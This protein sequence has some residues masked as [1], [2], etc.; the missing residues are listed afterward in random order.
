VNYCSGACELACSRPALGPA[1]SPD[2]ASIAFSLI[3][4]EQSDLYLVGSGGSGLRP[5]ADS[6]A[7]ESWPDWSPDGTR[8]AYST[9]SETGTIMVADADGSGAQ[10]LAI[11][12]E[13]VWGPD[14]S[15]DGSRIA[16]TAN[17]GENADIYTIQLD[18]SGLARI[19][20]DPAWDGNPDW[21]PDGSR[22][23]FTTWRNDNG[24]LYTARADGSDEQN[25]SENSAL[26]TDVATWS[27]DGKQI[28]F[29]ASGHSSSQG[30]LSQPLGIT[31][32]LLQSLILMGFVLRPS[33]AG[34][35]PSAGWRSF[36]I[37]TLMMS[38]MND[39]FHGPGD[40]PGGAGGDLL[41]LLKPSEGR[42]RFY[43]YIFAFLV[44]AVAYALYF[45]AVAIT[46]EL[47]WTIHLW[48]GTIV[49]AG[50]AG[51]LLA[52]LLA[53]FNREAVA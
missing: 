33:C 17:D 5:I 15:P 16:F 44:P 23:V 30:W 21:S 28:L 3:Q 9:H 40:G 4:E 50:V 46:S 22:L 8:L 29:S 39:T 1:W 20:E 53:Q 32:V 51:L 31:S 26:E 36:G 10:A 14:W 38:F 19:T 18:G 43:L 42:S 27:P 48:A 52:I 24:E 11:P 41:F 34:S 35:C 6:P 37:N 13:S 2:G 47:T 12:L 45:A 7:D 25:L 49:L